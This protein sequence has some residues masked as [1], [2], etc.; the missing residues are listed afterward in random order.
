MYWGNGAEPQDLDPQTDIA[1]T[2]SHILY[3]LFEGLVTQDPHDLHPIPGVAESWEISPDKRTYTFHLRHSARWSNGDA[4]TSKD[5]LR[6]YQRILSPKLGAQYA[7]YFWKDAAVVNAKD[8]YDGKIT[9]FA[10]VGVRAPDEHTLVIQ[11]VNPTAY[12]LSLLGNPPW[13]PVHVPS[14]LKYGELDEKATRWT[15]PGNLVGN[16]P[17][18]LK[19]WK[20][21]QEVVVEKNPQYWDAAN[22]RLKAIHF[23]PT[24]NI[25]TEEQDFHA[26][27]LHVT[28]D[29][30]VTKIDAYRANAPQFLQD[31]PYLGTYFLRFNVTDPVMK[32][33]RVRRA[34]SLAID[35]DG[36]VNNVMRGG[37]IPAHYFTPPDTAGYT[38]QAR[39]PT[40]FEDARRLLAEAGFP[41]GQ[42]LPPVDLLINTSG[43]H[44]AIAEVIQQTWREQL[45]VDA[46]IRNEEFKVYL[47]SQHAL[48]YQVCRAAWIGDYPDPF[49]FLGIFV[50]N[51][52]QNDSG[53]KNPEYDRLLADSL[54]AAPAARMED[55]QKAEKILL[56]EGPVAPIYFYTNVYLLRPSVKGWYSNILNRHMPKFLSLDENAASA[57]KGLPTGAGERRVADVPGR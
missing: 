39:Q 44:R 5:F 49:T 10:Q 38:A 21:E 25:D 31:T 12:F 19:D 33:P 52:E 46:H 45:H 37:Q 57:D 8:Y 43:N 28:N 53:W 40:D 34:L 30:P 23:Y 9:D 14:I 32:N 2:D 4:L 55:F 29:L 18:V 1:D 6:S 54:S 13:F 17:F 50:S 36:I 56:D 42:G 11:L 47:D 20:T 26:G 27:L 41:G 51:G 7:E 16:G 22:V 15:R 24:E 3:A 35:R 48:N